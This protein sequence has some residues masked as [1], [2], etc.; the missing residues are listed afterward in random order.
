ME[1]SGVHT[2]VQALAAQFAVDKR[3]IFR[4]LDL[5]EEATGRRSQLVPRRA[6]R[7]KG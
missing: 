4:D 7:K 3:T 1:H 5:M 2:T 6:N